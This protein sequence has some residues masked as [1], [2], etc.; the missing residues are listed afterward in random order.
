MPFWCGDVW[1]WVNLVRSVLGDV[2][3]QVMLHVY[4][5]MWGLERLGVGGFGE[6]WIW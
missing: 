5:C 4:M 2:W 6:G 1:E 3:K